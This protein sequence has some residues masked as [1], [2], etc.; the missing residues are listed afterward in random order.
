M[1]FLLN[2]QVTKYLCRVMEAVRW[3]KRPETHLHHS[4]LISFCSSRRMSLWVSSIVFDNNWLRVLRTQT[5]LINRFLQSTW[6]FVF[7]STKFFLIEL[8]FTE[9]VGMDWE[10]FEISPAREVRFIDYGNDEFEIV[11]VVSLL[12]VD[13]TASVLKCL[14]LHFFPGNWMVLPECHQHPNW[15]PWCLRDERSRFTS[16]DQ[17]RAVENCW[18]DRWSNHALNRR[19]NEPRTAR[20]VVLCGDKFFISFYLRLFKR[21]CWCVIPS[22]P[23]LWFSVAHVSTAEC[24]SSRRSLISLIRGIRRSSQSSDLSFGENTH[25]IRDC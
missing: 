22:Y 23:V 12:S 13:G 7:V 15:G 11:V 17:I 6:R 24:S 8:H 3:Q 19:E 4:A 10:Y 2:K 20:Y 21:E 16:S 18:S 14:L 1:D 5:F 25:S 9:T